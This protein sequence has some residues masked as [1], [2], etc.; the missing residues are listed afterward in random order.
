MLQAEG[1]E[2]GAEW[3]PELWAQMNLDLDLAPPPLVGL[4][5]RD[6]KPFKPHFLTL[7]KEAT[8]RME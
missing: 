2:G 5:A 8:Y 7:S 3:M 6:S 1:M 4:C